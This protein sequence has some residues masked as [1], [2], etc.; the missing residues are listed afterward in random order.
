M[1]RITKSK[2]YWN[3]RRR[4]KN[5]YTHAHKD[6]VHLSKTVIVHSQIHFCKIFCQCAFSGSHYEA[7]QRGQ[8][9][10]IWTFC[11]NF[12]IQRIPTLTETKCTE[13]NL[14]TD[15]MSTCGAGLVTCCASRGR[16]LY[17]SECH[18]ISY[19]WLTVCSSSDTPDAS[20]ENDAA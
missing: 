15:L 1:E 17:W 19:L 2:L 7:K 4:G 12:S 13:R 14:A 6:R 20:R 16:G 3:G 9:A 5:I 8:V 11:Q 18:N 10:L